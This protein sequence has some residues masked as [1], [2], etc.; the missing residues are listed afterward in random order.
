MA[1]AFT[2]TKGKME[3]F[4]CL[5]HAH[6]KLRIRH[7]RILLLYI[8]SGS[9]VIPDSPMNQKQV[10]HMYILL[11]S[12]AASNPYHILYAYVMQFLHHDSRGRPA[13]SRGNGHDPDPLIDT[14]DAFMLPVICNLLNIL[15]KSLNPFYPCRV[16]GK[17]CVGCAILP[18]ASD[19]RL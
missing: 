1:S 14:A 4:R 9:A 13:H 15:Q 5:N 16:S 11:Q 12:A 8:G 3:C 19:M 7:R 2:Y 18:A 10:S 6:K 17:D